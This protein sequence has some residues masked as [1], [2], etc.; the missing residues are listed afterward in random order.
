MAKILVV[1]DEASIRTFV[2]RVLERDG[3]HVQTAQD[4]QEALKLLESS[5]FD[6]LLSDI[7]MDRLDGI[8]LLREARVRYPDLV[9]I[10]LTG[11]AT[12]QSAVVAVN[13]GA[14]Q[15][16][17]KP[18]SNQDILSAVAGGLQE[19]DRQRRVGQLE[20]LASQITAVI[21]DSQTMPVIQ[22]EA[23]IEVGRLVLDRAA[24]KAML[25]ETPL[26]LTLTEFRL[27]NEL[28]ERP[29]AAIEYVPLVE[30]A[31]GYTASR[32]EAREIIGT[33]V[34]NLRRKLGIK[35]DDPLYVESVRGVG[36]RLIPDG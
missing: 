21:S 22:D 11:H 20:D 7:K 33:H 25:S 15:Y 3:Y 32:A 36:Y 5:E 16:L 13:E 24:Y 8:G 31:C 6:L 17:L 35:P 2:S 9:I 4:G 30:A 34:R 1:D 10:L 29:G 26:E 19:G 12:V 23:Q 27:L 28:S 18:A 14:Y